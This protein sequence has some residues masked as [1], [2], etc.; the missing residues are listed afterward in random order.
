MSAATPIET[1]VF[2]GGFNWPLFAG[3]AQGFFRDN[4]VE[5]RMTPTPDSKFQMVGLI[6][7]RFDVA[8]TAVDNVIAYV[9]GQ[10]AAPTESEPDI[11]A[12]MGC[13]NGFLRL[14][15][16]P[17]VTSIA[18]LKGRTIAVDALT[19]GYAFALFKALE[20]GGLSEGDYEL[21][22][23][24]GVKAR[25]DGLLAGGSFSATLLVSPLEAA[26]RRAG[27]NVLA[28]VS[29]S[30]APYQ[31]V[32]GA[33]RRGWAAENGRA[34]AGF[35]DGYRSAV[36][37]LREPGNRARAIDVLMAHVPGLTEVVADESYAILLDRE[38]GFFADGSLNRKGI[39]TVLD[40]R[41]RYANAAARLAPVDRYL[42]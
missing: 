2:P 19:T 41:R 9:N 25:F 20:N 23:A 42:M 30:L 32:V 16:T 28:D 34:I 8:M 39:E 37:W 38:T 35:R 22:S 5:V 33:V 13:D 10:G 36:G 18:D 17:D 6:D 14:V 29:A 27:C 12:F 15:A 7:G 4:G 26:A 24:G 31:G 1:I 11:V 21:V 40:L 3:Q